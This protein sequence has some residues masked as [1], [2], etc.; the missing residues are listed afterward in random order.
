MADTTINGSKLPPTPEQLAQQGPSMEQLAAT[1]AQL[2]ALAGPVRQ[3][4]GTFMRGLLVSA[5][6]FPPHIVL[7]VVAWQTGNLMAEAMQADIASAVQLRKMFMD[8]FSDGVRKAKM[9]QP[10]GSVTLPMGPLSAR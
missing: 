7:S 4:I 10:L 6:G 3:V 5:P 2:E 9:V 1:T 8:S